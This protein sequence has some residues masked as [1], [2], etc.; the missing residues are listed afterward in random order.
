M[1]MMGN[2]FLKAACALAFLC[3]AL[4]LGWRESA[5]ANLKSG[6]L[7]QERRDSAAEFVLESGSRK[8]PQDYQLRYR[9]A[10]ELDKRALAQMNGNMPF[11]EPLFSA[12][13]HLLAAL[14]LRCDI[15][16]HYELG[17]NFLMDGKMADALGHF[18]LAFFLS[19][20]PQDLGTWRELAETEQA[21][22]A[23][24]LFARGNLGRP[25]IMAYNT[26]TEFAPNPQKTPAV[27]FIES[28]LGAQPPEKWAEMGLADHRPALAGAFDA[29]GAHEREEIASALNAGG[30]GFLVD[31]MK[32]TP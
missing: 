22:A 21:K 31:A 8:N 11:R 28:F 13:Q 18:N 19:Q 2:N 7:L 30:F 29:L 20:N 26:M 1:P 3:A 25:L 9:L 10:V 24:E 27:K 16:T 6:T 5:Q 12:R 32:G 23:R 14:A 17:Q 4:F 15:F